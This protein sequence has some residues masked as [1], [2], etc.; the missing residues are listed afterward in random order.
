[1]ISDAKALETQISGYL[2]CINRIKEKFKNNTQKHTFLEFP[3]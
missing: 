3:S 2:Q 1:M